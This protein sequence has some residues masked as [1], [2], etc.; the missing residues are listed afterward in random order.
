M[1]EKFKSTFYPNCLSEWNKLEPELRLASSIA[2]FKKE[3]LSIIRPPSKICL[4][5]SRSKRVAHLTQLRVGLS[6]LNVHKF[7]H[8]F[9]DTID[10]M[11]PT[12]DGIENTEPFL[13]LCPSFDVQRRD[14]LAGIAE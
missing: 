4:W 3:L 6:K 8:D 13:R 7:N 11:C 10:P 2:V 12:N 1:H 9:R 14:L 5:N